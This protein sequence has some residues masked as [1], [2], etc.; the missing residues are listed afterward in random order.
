MLLH[1]RFK[2][3]L[4][5]YRTLQRDVNTHYFPSTHRLSPWRERD[6]HP[7]RQP[8]QVTIEDSYKLYGDSPHLLGAT[9]RSH[10]IEGQQLDCR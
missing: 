3:Y 4:S 1:S 8:P 7:A 10:R 9:E 6:S 2:K 5:M